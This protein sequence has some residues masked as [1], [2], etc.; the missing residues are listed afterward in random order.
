MSGAAPSAA[1]ATAAVTRL[2]APLP[3]WPFRALFLGYPLWWLL[4]L[5]PFVVFGF[6]L[7]AL[8]LMLGRG[9]GRILL[10]RLWWWWLA[11]LSWGLASATMIDTAGRMVGFTQRWLSLI[12]ATALLV[13]VYNAPHTLTRRTVLTAMSGFGVWMTIGGYLG[14]A[15]PWGRISTPMAAVLPPSL[16]ANPYVSELLNPR[17]AEVQQPWGAASA[18]VRPS[19]PFPYTNAWGHAFVLLVPVVLALAVH[20][21]RRTR[22]VLLVLVAAAL[23]PAL[24]TLNRG[25]FVGLG[26]GLLYVLGRRI[27][28]A[29]L[30]GVLGLALVAAAAGVVVVVSGVLDRLGER[31]TTSSTTRDRAD[32]YRE[33][34]Q[35]TL[36][37]PLVGWGAPRP[38]LTKQVSVGTQGHFWYLMFSHG[39]VGLALFLVAVW[40]TALLTR[41]A[42][43]LHTVLLHTPVVV[44]GVMLLF[45]G[46]DA[47]HLLVAMTCAMLLARP[48][49]APLTWGL[50]PVSAPASRP[51]GAV[52]MAP[53]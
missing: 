39:F 6:G 34:F 30:T 51:A 21:S 35:R 16:A 37:S 41:R 22:W 7:C 13:Y 52:S 8:A 1:A 17:F 11:F 42:V 5:G 25:V 44:I 50:L 29:S 24:A 12:G 38:S 26:V 47:L 18:F 48:E 4:G 33:A 40:G 2:P 31:T 27:R 53:T 15:F 46:V 36:D 32:L 43:D 3:A 45:Y 49:P 20:A 28:R 19:A 23:P 9:R 10:P 14:M